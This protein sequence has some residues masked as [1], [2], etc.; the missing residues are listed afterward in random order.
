MT[1]ILGG[2]IGSLRG[3]AIPAYELI[4]TVDV[5]TAPTSIVFSS[6]PQT[7]KHLQ[8]RWVA[9]S[10][11]S[12]G[13]SSNMNITINGATS[14]Y[15]E[16]EMVG[17]G[18]AVSSTNNF[19]QSDITL[20]RSIAQATTTGAVS[21]GILDILDYSSTT[22]NKTIKAFY[23]LTNVETLVRLVS[24]LFGNTAAITNLTFTTG[25]GNFTNVTRFSLYGIK[26]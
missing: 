10:S 3:A 26:G 7:Y 6:I 4:S 11:G 21:A 1:G 8:I 14:G 22:K 9:K 18:T 20:S 24:G 16:H 17:N 13:A 23:G 25:S 19:N 5:T 12:T 2:L 15:S